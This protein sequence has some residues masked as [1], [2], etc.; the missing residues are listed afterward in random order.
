MDGASGEQLQ[1]QGPARRSALH[2]R[3]P[4]HTGDAAGEAN[5]ECGGAV[6]GAARAHRHPPPPVQPPPYPRVLPDGEGNPGD[7][8]P[9]GAAHRHPD[10]PHPTLLPAARPPGHRAGAGGRGDAGGDLE[11]GRLEARG[12]Q[13]GHA[14]DADG[15]ERL[16]QGPQHLSAPRRHQRL[17]GHAS[18]EVDPGGRRG[19]GV[20][21]AEEARDAR[22]PLPRNLQILRLLF[23]PLEPRAPSPLP[24]AD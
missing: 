14:G 13:G 21:A 6:A 22:H 15:D 3:Q 5:R 10:A 16:P 19:R 9:Q 17:L 8:V 1:R 18:Q 24:R 11:E 12:E 2:S 20:A 23:P 4:P 7:A